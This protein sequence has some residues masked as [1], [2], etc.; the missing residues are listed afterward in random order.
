LPGEPR[1]CSS[2]PDVAV[3]LRLRHDGG[4][5]SFIATQTSFGTATDVT[6]A[7]LSI[8]SFFPADAQTAKVLRAG[9]SNT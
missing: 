5:L 3:P 8:E 9:Q 2:R 7:E 4:K 1:I 6:V